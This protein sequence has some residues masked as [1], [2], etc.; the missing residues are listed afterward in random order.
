M[1]RADNIS[2]S[3]RTAAIRGFVETMEKYGF[4]SVIYINK[5]FLLIK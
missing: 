3:S 4:S 1:E 5:D 2:T